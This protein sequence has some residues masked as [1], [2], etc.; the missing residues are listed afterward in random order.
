MVIK[1]KRILFIVYICLLWLM[2][3]NLN[4]GEKYKIIEQKGR[5]VT[6]IA[7]GDNLIHD[8]IYL[9]AKSDN[10]F[11]F[12]PIYTQIKPI[13]NGFNLKFINQETILG[14]V[15]LGLSSYPLFNSPFE[16]GDA[17][18]DL[19][20]NLISIANNH[21]LDKG[22]AGVLNALN[23][24]GLQPVIYSGAERTDTNSHTKQFVVNNIRFA[25]IAYTYGTNGIPYPGGKSY[26]ANLYADE[27]AISDIKAVRGKVDVILVSM[28]WGEE[29][30]SYPNAA[31]R[32][33]AAVLADLGVDLIIG[34]HPHVIQPIEFITNAAG[35]QTMVIYSLGN[36]LSGQIGINRLIGMAVSIEI[37]KSE[38]GIVLR[39]PKAKLLYHY[40]DYESRIYRVIPCSS[41]PESFASEYHDLFLKIKKTV[42][43]Y[44]TDIE[45]S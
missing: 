23:Y 5:L 4:F 24:W 40:R 22:E 2:G 35:R 14:G 37:E 34:H 18:V 7:V 13:I 6:L 30:Q 33:Q 36:F 3:C 43:Y 42:Q 45:V 32:Q 27:K 8:S 41:L 11:D 16:V 26:L 10:G 25:F 29:Y 12:K 39:S 21:T 19:G 44:T 1:I 28:H 15:D 9:S 38:K 20:F 31:Q 17:L